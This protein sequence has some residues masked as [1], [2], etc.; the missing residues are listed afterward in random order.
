[1]T[2]AGGVVGEGGVLPDP[3]TPGVLWA[4]C[5]VEPVVVPAKAAKKQI[6]SSC[7]IAIAYAYSAFQSRMTLRHAALVLVSEVQTERGDRV[8]AKEQR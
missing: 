1:M 3:E 6:A 5:L 7:I 8:E 4:S 2:V